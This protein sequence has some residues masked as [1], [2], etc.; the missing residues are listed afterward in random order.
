M[1]MLEEIQNWY[2]MH[3]NND[4][5]HSYGVSID[6]LDNPG[7]IVKI[8]LND[9]LLEDVVFPSVEEGTPED[10]ESIFGCL[11]DNNW[12]KCYKEKNVWIGMGSPDKLEEILK[13]FL[14]WSKTHTD[15]SPWDSQINIIERRLKTIDTVSD[16]MECLKEI[17]KELT[18]IPSEHP[19]KKETIKLFY[20][21]LNI[22]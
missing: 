12:V 22:Y 21:C 11:S 14:D 3:C 13:I 2:K 1:N 15:P 10:S 20:E 7:W 18:K 6:T 16:K 17:Y 8:S 9:T 4:W 19:R 5:E